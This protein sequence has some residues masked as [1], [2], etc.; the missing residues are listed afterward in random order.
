MEK[1]KEI[2]EFYDKKY[3]K[4]ELVKAI[5]SI[6]KMY[7]QFETLLQEHLTIRDYIFTF[8]SY[9]AASEKFSYLWKGFDT[10]LD[11]KGTVKLANIFIRGNAISKAKAEMAM[12]SFF[13]QRQKMA[14]EQ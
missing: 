11:A 14:M 3:T 12:R 13:S 7:P 9:C 6:D 1:I 5:N 10:K 4:A 2:E 8:L